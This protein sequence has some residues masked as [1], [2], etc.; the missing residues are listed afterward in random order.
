[1]SHS[2]S[3][4]KDVTIRANYKDE[5]RRFKAGVHH[6]VPSEYALHPYAVASGVKILTD[7]DVAALAPPAPFDIEAEFEKRLAPVRIT[8]RACRDEMSEEAF[9]ALARHIGLPEAAAQISSAPRIVAVIHG[10]GKQITDI[11]E[12]EAP[13]AGEADSADPETEEEKA[14]DAALA[15]RGETKEA[16]I[17]QA[18]ELGVVVDGR[19]GLAKL[20][21]AIDEALA[22]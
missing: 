21:A 12:L 20:Q 22:A 17:A 18:K 2:I 14:K 11:D 13:A 19:W 6:D 8:L 9:T 10:E 3:F 4:P 16:L 5:P 1:M 15:E 7:E